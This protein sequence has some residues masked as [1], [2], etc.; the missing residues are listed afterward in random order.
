MS[1]S[2]FCYQTEFGKG[3]IVVMYCKDYCSV[4]ACV[5]ERQKI[6]SEKDPVYPRL[7]LFRH[8]G[9]EG[10]LFSVKWTNTKYAS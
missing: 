3:G 9:T 1:S 2:Q 6:E 8:R 10:Q 7:L 5:C 4:I